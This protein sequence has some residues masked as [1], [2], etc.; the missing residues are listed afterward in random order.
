MYSCS[1]FPLLFLSTTS[2]THNLVV[3]LANVNELG[4][5]GS[6]S[7]EDSITVVGLGYLSAT[8]P[9]V[10]RT[11]LGTVL[12]ADGTTVNDPSSVGDRLGN[13]LG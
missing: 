8:I 2:R 6:T 7:N 12:S 1:H 4:L 3:G 13:S 10:K 9:Q 5:E 11:K